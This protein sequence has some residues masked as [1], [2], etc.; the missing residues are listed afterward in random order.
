MF[1][2]INDRIMIG[3][4]FCHVDKIKQDIHEIDLITDG[5]HKCKGAIPSLRRIDM[6]KKMENRFIEIDM[7]NHR[8]I[9]DI[10][11]ILDPSAWARKYLTAASVSWNFLEFI[12]SGM[13]LRRL[14]SIPAHRNIQLED[15]MAIKE[16]VIMIDERRCPRAA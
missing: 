11:R 14:S 3:A 9:L 12:S 13:N 8:D 5:Y 7:L 4:S 2:V 6:I 1:V 15:E 16:L 10:R